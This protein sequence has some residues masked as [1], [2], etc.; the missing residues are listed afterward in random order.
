MRVV[1]DKF[2]IKL[3]YP[4]RSC[5]ECGKYPCFDGIE[6]TISDFASY[7]CVYYGNKSKIVSK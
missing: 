2:G 4:E 6:N 3:K 7:G 5:K 1:K